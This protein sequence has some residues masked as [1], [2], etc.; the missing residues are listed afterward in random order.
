MEPR[1][2]T[3]KK[4]TP[5]PNELR[6]LIQSGLVDQFSH[7]VKEHWG[8][9]EW[10]VEGRIYEKEMT[11]RIGFL[12]RGQL[13]QNNIEI[14]VDHQKKPLQI[15]PTVLDAASALMTDFLAAE[16]ALRE[17]DFSE[18][19]GKLPAEEILDLPRTWKKFTFSGMDV[20]MQ[21]TTLNSRLEEEANALLGTLEDG[22]VRGTDDD[23]GPVHH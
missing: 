21:Y 3:S 10:I 1:L 15:L 11:L 14:S 17:T 2:N 9:C 22:L 20:Y 19:K 16:E 18:E 12:Q 5:I 8:D 23:E 7:E 4:W 6:E 13:K